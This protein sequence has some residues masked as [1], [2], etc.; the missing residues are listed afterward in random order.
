[1]MSLLLKT[2]RA[3]VRNINNFNKYKGSIAAISSLQS[4]SYSTNNRSI[5]N[6]KSLNLLNGNQINKVTLIGELL[7]LFINSYLMILF[8]R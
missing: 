3:F 6:F 1:M 8:K 7:I 5:N 4:S 2:S